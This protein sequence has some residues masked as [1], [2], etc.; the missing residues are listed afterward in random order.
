MDRERGLR[1]MF[2]GGDPGF[3]G[4]SYIA[5][6]PLQDIQEAIN[7]YLEKD[8]QEYAKEPIAMLGAPG[9]N[10]LTSP[11]NGIARPGGAYP[12]PGGK[13]AIYI[14]GSN[15]NIVNPDYTQTIVGNLI[16][17]AGPVCIK[18]NG[19]LTNGLGGYAVIVDGLY[20]YY[21]LLSGV[22]YSFTFTGSVTT[23]ST[24]ITLPGT[25]PNGLIVSN[26]TTLKSANGAYNNASQGE[27]SIVSIDTIGLTITTV[28]QSSITNGAD[29]FTLTIPVFGQITDA[30][31]LGAQ[32]VDFIEGWLIF[33]NPGTR[34]F[35][36]T[37]PT[38]YQMLFPGAFYALKDSS[39]DNLITLQANDR[40]LWLIGE[41]TSEVWYNA[42]NPNFAFARIPGVG[43]QI[44]CSAFMSISRLGNQLV[45]LGANE[46]GQNIVVIQSQYS[47]ERI[48]DHGME[49]QISQYATVSDAFGYCYEEGGHIFYMLSFPTADVTWCFDSTTKQWHKRLSWD[50]VLGQY[51]RHR[52]ACFMNFQDTRVIGDYQFGSLCEMSRAFYTDA[53]FP[54]RALRR[55]PH[56]WQKANRG[57][58]FFSQ[59]QIEFTPGV[60]LQSGQGSN[61]QCM[62][63]FSD[64]GGF[65]WSNEIWVG[66]GK[67][68]QY[69]N[70]AIWYML[71]EARDRVWE[72][73]ITD[74]VARDIIGATSFV[75]AAA[76]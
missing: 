76:A 59:L 12:L 52:S 61:P 56:I 9:L 25:L 14:S 71:G 53:G 48:S 70:R 46:Q 62:L 22:P 43:P 13:Q 68:G 58:I 37:G 51:H 1:L 4:A 20:A 11:G 50:P 28:A 60:G 54:L 31:F 55:S 73:V 67:V 5:A 69:K 34:T 15:V 3:C 65:T 30:G 18:D 40:E 8:P 26:T 35:Y 74:P 44:G 64:D 41:R 6:D 57:R 21:Y 75:E 63:R 27:T 45:W 66:I 33:N 72:I 16:T 7:W 24:L 23:N 38:P 49:N 36:T 10:A 29:T 47:W 42:G 2:E 17:T 32:K 39:T 19:V